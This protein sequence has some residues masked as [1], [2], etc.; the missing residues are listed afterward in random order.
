MLKIL[1]FTRIAFGAIY[2]WYV[3]HSL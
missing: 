2:F 1:K 3:R